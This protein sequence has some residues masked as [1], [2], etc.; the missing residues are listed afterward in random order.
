[1]ATKKKVVPTEEQLK[2]LKKLAKALKASEQVREIR[3]RL[4]GFVEENL[5]ALAEGVSVE[6]LDLEVKLSKTLYA[7]ETM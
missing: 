1:M 3:A 6:G 2:E 7:E 5:D 4:K